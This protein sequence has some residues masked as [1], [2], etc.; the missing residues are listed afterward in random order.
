MKHNRRFAF[1]FNFSFLILHFTLLSVL[2]AAATPVSPLPAPP[3]PEWSVLAGFNIADPE[4]A[5]A[6]W[7]PMKGSA[8][9]ECVNAGADANVVRM[10]CDFTS[11][12]AERASWNRDL[13]MN[14]E[15]CQGVRFNLLC[16]DPLPISGFTLYLRSGA[17]WYFQRFS[18]EGGSDW[19]TVEIRKG[20]MDT[21]GEPAGWD[22]IE[23]LRVSAWRGQ[24]VDTEFYMANLGAF[25]KPPEIAVLQY[26]SSLKKGADRRP[27]RER[28]QRF[29]DAFD[30]MS[31][32][33]DILSDLS[34]AG[35]QLK[36]IR[37]L[38]LPANSA[39]PDKAAEVVSAFV[40]RGGK[41]LMFYQVPS[42]L[43]EIAGFERGK[44]IQP[45]APGLFSTIAFAPGVLP[46]A[47]GRVRQDARNIC[48]SLPVKGRSQAAAWWLDAGGKATTYPA[49]LVSDN[50]VLATHV[51]REMDSSAVQQMIAAMLARL[52]PDL[53]RKAVAGLV[54]NVA[55]VEPLDKEGEF[56]Q[57]ILAG[58]KNVAD[59]DQ[60]LAQVAEMRKKAA[61]LCSNGDLA[62]ATSIA[63][64]ARKSL[65][66][67][68]C[69]AQEPRANEFRGFWC[70]NAFG[71]DGMTWDE[72]VHNLA[73]NGIT[74]I[75][76]NMLWGGAAFY[77]S[78]VLPVAAAVSEKGDQLRECLAA[79]KKYG[80]Q[81]HVWKVCW[82]CGGHS[83]P[84][85]IKK[86]REAGRLQAG[87][88]GKSDEDW[89]CP[90]NPLNQQQEIDAMVEVTTRYDVDGIHFDYI[91]YPNADHCFCPGCRARFEEAIGRKVA[92]WPA[93]VRS[94][95]ALLQKWYDFRRSNIT[96][97]VRSVSEIVRKAKP[98]LRISAAVFRD[99]PVDRDRVGQDW[100]AWLDA[101]YLDFVCPMDYERNDAIF[102]R[103][104]KRQL[105]WASSSTGGSS[106]PN[107]SIASI[108]S[109]ASI[110]PTAARCYPGIGLSVWSHPDAIVHVCEQI[111]LARSL[112]AGGFMIFNYSP[113]EA[114]EIVPLLG[115]GITRIR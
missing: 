19:E 90:S 94:D 35:S 59:M 102:G 4:T 15:S 96:R 78:E 3:K 95:P 58:R 75:F 85:Y 32:P 44:W 50:A 8:P 33:C 81:C 60:R 47:P 88:D 86:M 12:T 34:L 49:V 54:A 77:N 113:T 63:L 71:V 70:H 101:G 43:A 64:A 82:N 73:D 114:L 9:V 42:A 89:L 80:V 107:A 25:G 84:E 65:I 67:L 22:K 91:R 99:W 20:E 13:P 111:K 10:P 62:G 112:G 18:V 106:A 6:A 108:P 83:S 93:D 48:A 115:R 55:I 109:I 17:G 97:V 24:N 100:K 72:A 27:L 28:A 23:G 29:T 51:L 41:L 37:L 31:L 52:D 26:D 16:R 79:C 57:A 30:A 36:N 7:K 2:P 40:K 98:S 76:P 14:L 61:A 53:G 87:F 1:I 46:G 103:M 21:E 104:V 45:Q 66:G 5:K 74:A 39:L 69:A 92:N 110:G 68:Y 105:E 11:S 56:Q 38:I